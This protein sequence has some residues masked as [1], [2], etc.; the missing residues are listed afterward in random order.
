MKFFFT[1]TAVALV[2]A[3]SLL[4]IECDTAFGFQGSSSTTATTTRTL[5]STTVSYLHHSPHHRHYS[6]GL[7]PRHPLHQDVFFPLT[8]MTTKNYRQRDHQETTGVQYMAAADASASTSSTE[9]RGFWNKVR[10]VR[11]FLRSFA[12]LLAFNKDQ[13]LGLFFGCWPF[14]SCV[15]FTFS[16]LPILTDNKFNVCCL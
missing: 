16:H 14:L 5:S 6:H 11:S 13:T 10:S 4:L 9:K 2:A 7:R 3:S 8:T 1:T 15:V 12:C